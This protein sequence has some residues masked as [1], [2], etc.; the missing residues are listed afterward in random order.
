MAVDLVAALLGWL[1]EEAGGRAVEGVGR[2]VLGDP[3]ERAVREVV[4]SAIDDT[5][6]STG[7][8]TA[9]AERLGAVLRE[10][11]AIPEGPARADRRRPDKGAVRV[12][13]GAGSA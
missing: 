8:V 1:T 3:Q 5:V 6:A 2:L 12:G 9:E 4:A 13:C 11:H 10:R 7:L